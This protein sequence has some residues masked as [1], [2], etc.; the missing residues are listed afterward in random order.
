M[1][2]FASTRTEIGDLVG[3]FLDVYTLIVFIYIVTNLVFAFG[4]RVP[5]SRASNAVLDFLRDTVEPFLRLF[6]FL[7]LR[8]GPLDLTPMVA[9]LALNIVGRIIVGVIHG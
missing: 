8:F 2:A 4:I 5:Y 1:L 6:R 9:I 7:P 3:T